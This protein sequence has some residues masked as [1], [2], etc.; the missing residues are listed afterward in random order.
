MHCHRKTNRFSL[1]GVV[2]SFVIIGM[3][4]G[5]MSWQA[6]WPATDVAV[7]AQDVSTLMQTADQLSA[8]ADNREN[9]QAAMKAY[10]RVL[11][12]DPHHVRA[13]TDLANQTILMG[14]AHTDSREEKGVHY[15]TAMRLCERAMYTNAN[16]RTLADQGMAPWEACHVLEEKDIPAMMFWST[17]VLYLFKEVLTFPEQVFNLSWVEHTGPFLER[18]EAIDPQWGGGAIQFTQS[19]YFGILPGVMGGD[20]DRSKQYLKEAVAFGAPWMLSRWGRAKYFQVRDQNRQGFE[21]DL[22]WVLQQDVSVPV[23]AFC[24]RAYF[25]KDARDA[26]ENVDRYF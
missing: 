8:V 16:F 21:E 9:L 26:L 19:L 6:N 11:E 15:R 14:A 24:W 25:H 2:F 17:A 3:F 20:A 1:A 22:R 12:E 4:T 5:C 23:E 10:A 13:L 7:Q 18:M